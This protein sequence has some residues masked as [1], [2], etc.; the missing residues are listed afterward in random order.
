MKRLHFIPILLAAMA[1]MH[2]AAGQETELPVKKP[3]LPQQSMGMT[4]EIT[5]QQV[6]DALQ[7]EGDEK[8]LYFNFEDPSLYGEI[9]VGP[10]PFE[11]HESDLHYRRYRLQSSL[12]QG[13]GLIPIRRF[14]TEKYDANEWADSS[15]NRAA[16]AVRL[17]LW[18]KKDNSVQHH[19]FRDILVNFKRM[20]GNFE[21]TTTM[22]EGPFVNLL[23]SD[24]GEPQGTTVTISWETLQP[25]G[26]KV[27]IKGLKEYTHRADD[28]R[29]HAI[30]IDGLHH[31]SLYRYY[32]KSGG[33]RSP[34]YSF[35][36][37]PE[38]GRGEVTIAYSG[39]SREGVGG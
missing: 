15:V 6:Y 7:K 5:L 34:V 10:Y 4:N 39:D 13:R 9:Y 11:E 19:G 12:E 21:L 14:Y 33:T 3:D 38:K 24:D 2:P 36:T 28:L 17:D 27:V 23:R 37:A 16:V 22:T 31:D 35:R 26:G 29:H 1:L 20:D 32:V 30:E 18:Q 25:S 8:G